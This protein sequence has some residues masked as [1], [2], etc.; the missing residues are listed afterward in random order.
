[1]AWKFSAWKCRARKVRARKFAAW[2][3]LGLL[4]VLCVP[5]PVA[6]ADSRA[7]RPLQLQLDLLG[8]SVGYHF[9]EL[10][11]VG[12]TH[13]LEVSGDSFNGRRGAFDEE[14]PLYGQQGVDNDDRDF[15]ARSAIEVRFSPWDFGVYFAGA[16]LYVDGDEQEVKWD[17]RGRRVGRGDYK[18]GL[19]ADIEG[20]S[21][22]TP[23][24]GVGVNHVFD[25]GLSLNGGILIGILQPGTPDVEV[26][27]TDSS[28]T[29]DDLRRFR[30]KIEVEFVDLPVMLHLA[31][32]YN[33]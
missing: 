13:Q 6:L 22:L 31:V 29:G 26:T 33:F 3:A 12:V 16:L 18:T 15:G 28:V 27:A 11:Y 23:A 32:G 9:S 30:E 25:F 8:L 1:M 2:G 5:Q 21:V 14:T 7:E 20:N 24:G 19:T 10:V 4:A 17:V